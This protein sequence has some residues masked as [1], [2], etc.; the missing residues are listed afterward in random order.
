MG[1]G[2][3][4][5]KHTMQHNKIYKKAKNKQKNIATPRSSRLIMELG[6]FPNA[7]RL[8]NVL[9]D[10]SKIWILLLISLFLKM[11]WAIAAEIKLNEDYKYAHVW[12]TQQLFSSWRC[13]CCAW[14]KTVKIRKLKTN[15]EAKK[16]KRVTYSCF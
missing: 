5:Q 9:N 7:N 14:N 3:Q 12:F 15:Q 8:R 1:L 10:F 4:S 2:N 11:H 13:A 6:S 16:I